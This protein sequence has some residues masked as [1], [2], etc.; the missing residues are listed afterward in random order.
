MTVKGI[1]AS[2]FFQITWRR[3]CWVSSIKNWQIFAAV[4]RACCSFL[5]EVTS[6]SRVLLQQA[7]EIKHLNN[8]ELFA[9]LP[10]WMPN[11]AL[12]HCP[13]P[14]LVTY[15]RDLFLVLISIYSTQQWIF[16]AQ[17]TLN[18]PFV[19]NL[20]PHFIYS[21]Q[22]AGYYFLSLMFE[23]DLP[24]GINVQLHWQSLEMNFSNFLGPGIPAWGTYDSRK[25]RQVK[26]V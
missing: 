4:S 22:S 19:I 12:L 16:K 3:T 9:A 6:P 21:K 24:F 26:S 8:T 7:L 23:A 17:T 20:F 13:S 5:A 14:G 10:S 25:S 11:V 15:P 2:L 18:N 1:W